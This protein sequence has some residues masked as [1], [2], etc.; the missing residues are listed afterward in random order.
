MRD[1][2]RDVLFLTPTDT[3]LGRLLSHIL[4]V[5]S[6]PT[7]FLLTGDR[8][9]RALAGPSVGVGPLTAYQQPLTVTEAAIAAQIHQPLDVHSR[10]AA[11]IT[12]DQKVAVDRLAQAG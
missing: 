7:L 11:Q 6:R 3:S 2:G 1:A 9:G 5:L 10:L 12:L 8:L 4:K